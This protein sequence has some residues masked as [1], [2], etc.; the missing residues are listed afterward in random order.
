VDDLVT[1]LRQAVED[2]HAEL[3]DA[4]GYLAS[5]VEFSHTDDPDHREV[6][7]TALR[8]EV[9]AKR[10]R[11]DHWAWLWAGNDLRQ[12]LAERGL[13]MEAMPYAS[14]PGFRDEWRLT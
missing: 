5:W 10:A 7:R 8:A 9:E 1:W 4:V 14:R 2:Q 11:I 12:P 13:L 6:L 3:M